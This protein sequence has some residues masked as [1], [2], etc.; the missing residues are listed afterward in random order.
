M[1]THFVLFLLF[2]EK[3]PET[4]NEVVAKLLTIKKE[5]NEHINAPKGEIHE[6]FRKY[7]AQ[8]ITHKTQ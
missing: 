3:S 8:P 4:V 5:R 6:K 2:L 1:L 7:Q